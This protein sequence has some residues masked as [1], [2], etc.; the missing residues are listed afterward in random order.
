MPETNLS[1]GRA[2]V[3]VPARNEADALPRLL[4]SLDRQEGI[5][6]GARLRVVVL[7]NNCTDETVARLRAMESNAQIKNLAL[8]II[9]A[10]IAPPHAHVGTA[11][12]RALDAGVA[13]LEQDGIAD[14]VLLSTDADAVAPPDWVAANLRALRNAEIVG[15]RLVLHGEQPAGDPRLAALHARIEQYWVA[16]R[17]LEEVFDPPAHDPAPR[18]GD[19]VAAS[20]ALH[21]DLYRRVGGLPVLPCGEDNAL[22]ARV[23]WH[24]G[25]VRHCPRVSIAVSDRGTGRV[26]GGMATEML[27]RARV[28]K[29][30]E[31]YA[32]PSATHWRALI[33]RRRVLAS[34]FAD[35]AG[36]AASLRD[37]GISEFDLAAIDL[38]TCPN[39]IA[40]VERVEAQVGEG[41]PEAVPVPLDEALA[42]LHAMVAEAQGIPAARVA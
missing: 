10:E 37:F 29:G 3:C 12:R 1:L 6:D 40:L 13:W 24:G 41:I 27:R 39:A 19:H 28:V 4:Q 7:A 21:V 22:V 35:P 30:L 9:E 16:V 18:H 20:L 42:G 33:E 11:R 5:H 2:V 31:S 17:R 26:T 25:R 15:G 23:R 34:C 8:R 14:G 36:V 38:E 32:L